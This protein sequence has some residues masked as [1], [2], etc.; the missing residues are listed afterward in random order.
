M[1]KILIALVTVAGLAQ[2]LLPPQARQRLGGGGVP[3]SSVELLLAPSSAAPSRRGRTTATLLLRTISLL[4][5]TLWTRLEWFC[6]GA[7]LI[8]VVGPP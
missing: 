7:R 3:R 4:R 1:R 5:T 2:Q 6:L 8:V